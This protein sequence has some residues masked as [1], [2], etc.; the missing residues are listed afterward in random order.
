MKRIIILMYPQVPQRIMSIIEQERE[1]FKGILE[2]FP[3]NETIFKAFDLCP[4]DSVKVVIIGQDPYHGPGQANGLCFSVNEDIKPPPSL[5]NIIKEYKNDIG[6]E[7]DLK[8]L[9]K[10]GV[11]LL[12]STLTV[13]QGKPN[14]HKDIGWQE[15][16]DSIIKYISDNKS[17]VVF[18]LW[19]NYA[20]SKSKMIDD[21]KHTIL[22]ATHPSPLGANKGGWFGTKHFSKANAILNENLFT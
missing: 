2:I 19:G 1:K 13:V 9:A 17:N 20:K 22:S 16:T 18:M 10:C 11:L 6:T 12:N 4:F 7:P 8:L 21:T 5:L 14:S 3:Q 15:Y